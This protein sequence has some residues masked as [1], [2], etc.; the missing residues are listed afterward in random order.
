MRNLV[1]CVV[2]LFVSTVCFAQELQ[3]KTTSLSNGDTL[4]NRTFMSKWQKLL[5]MTS[6]ERKEY[7]S[8]SQNIGLSNRS[9]EET[10]IGESS[11]LVIPGLSNTSVITFD[12]LVM[13]ETSYFFDS[14]GDENPDVVFNTSDP[15]GFGT[16][17]PGLNMLYIDEPSLEGTTLLETDLRVDFLQPTTSKIKF[18]FALC[19]TETSETWVSFKVFDSDENQLS[20]GFENGKFTFPDGPNS[21][22]SN[23][24][25]GI[26][27]VNFTGEAAYALFNF[28]TSSQGCQR[29]VMDNFEYISLPTD[30]TIEDVEY[31]VLN[32]ACRS[33]ILEIGGKEVDVLP[34]TIES[35]NNIDIS[36]TVKYQGSVAFTSSLINE[37]ILSST[38]VDDDIAPVEFLLD[39]ITISNLAAG[40]SR[41]IETTVTIPSGIEPGPY[42]I[43]IT[44]DTDNEVP[45]SNEENNDRVALLTI[46]SR[47][48]VFD[49][50]PDFIDNKGNIIDD[51]VRFAVGGA[52][53]VGAATDGVTKVL[54]SYESCGPG[55]VEFF[56]GDDFNVPEDGGFAKL[57]KIGRNKSVNVELVDFGDGRFV[58]IC[59]Y[60]VPDN[61]ST[62]NGS[63]DIRTYRD[64]TFSAIFFPADEDFGGPV[65][66][67]D[68]K[69]VRPPVVLIHG[70]WSEGSTW[71]FPLVTD[72]RFS[73]TIADYKKTHASRFSTNIKVPYDFITEAINK[74]RRNM[75]A[76][77]QVDLVGHSMGGI[78]SRNHVSSI[79]YK[80][81]ANFLLGNVHKLITIDTPHTGSPWGNLL[82]PIKDT[83]IA[84]LL[85]TVEIDIIGGAIDDL[86][87]GS[88]AIGK[89][90]QTLIPS[91]ALVGIGGPDSDALIFIS[92][93]IG[94]AYGILAF[95]LDFPD[96]FPSL[97]NDVIVGLESQEGGISDDAISD[98]IDGTDGIHTY[99]TGSEIY[100][101]RI[102]ELLDSPPMEP[103]FSNFPAVT[104]LSLNKVASSKIP[105]TTYNA[106]NVVTK[107]SSISE[108]LVISSPSEGGIVSAGDTIQVIAVPKLD[109]LI[110]S[111]IL[112]AP[113]I[114]MV[115]G[116]AAFEFD[117]TIPDDYI[118][119][120]EISA[121]GKDI[122]GEFFKSNTIILQ[123]TTEALLES[124]NVI[125][126][127]SLMSFIGDT[128]NLIV[129]GTFD[130]GE[131]REITSSALDF[132]TYTTSNSSIVTV[133]ENGVMTAQ[134]EGDAEVIVQASD[135]SG[136]PVEFN[137]PVRVLKNVVVAKAGDDQFVG[138]VTEVTLD[139]GG[140][141]D[142]VMGPEPLSYAWT[143]V[144]GSSSTVSL[145]DD[146]SANPTFTT[147][148][149]E[150][151]YVFELVVSDSIEIAHDFVIIN[152][153]LPP[154]KVIK[155][156]SF[157]TSLAHNGV[158]I[159]WVTNSEI[160]NGGFNILR[161]Q[162]DTENGTNINHALIPLKG[163]ETQGAYY[164]FLDTDVIPGQTYFYRLEDI[165]FTNG[166]NRVHM[167]V[168]IT[169]E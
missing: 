26:I 27:E 144:V 87:K 148:S 133:S 91:H 21:P 41:V 40:E 55:K 59:I 94:K 166:I 125:P 111:V 48:M 30:I 17:G 62:S 121:A 164:S 92:G 2:F 89:I 65:E 149:E 126:K 23:A 136:L 160:N 123:V 64:I 158:L 84:N 67:M 47:F 72:N 38:E 139:G 157:T 102:V 61:F 5:P 32:S 143:Q 50:N 69:L 39:T 46:G 116:S 128:K 168:P 4:N 122:N 74:S 106:D 51:P 108:E 75:I 145:S 138:L 161:S 49:A 22:Q 98:P 56:L 8:N 152:A 131:A 63:P 11:N 83:I 85:N 127:E 154:I 1:L 130:D 147:P 117:L 135:S 165:D 167:A 86:A 90:Q 155:A 146:K 37:I 134:G 16:G 118:G 7:F 36:F 3:V 124:I 71:T 44:V 162:S 103:L 6:K 104:S 9:V 15:F 110:D 101:N 153:E 42:E 95:F 119:T 82:V 60:Q 140:S 31:S 80:S 76:A 28:N 52:E 57:G 163:N 13:S 93:Y 33:T 132:I 29:Y 78:L 156:I 54:L 73:V 137:V 113:D 12:D 105:T 120:F 159:E 19:D 151:Q 24:P 150:G 53:R 58:G 107:L 169:I 109:V 66:T 14:D 70:I 81:K 35:G 100:S 88:D 34:G 45:E 68:F 20:S 97:Q 112:V 43:T 99:N 18:G 25:E 141:F 142:R 10:D 79:Y 96:L 115:D 129:F 77:T 114:V